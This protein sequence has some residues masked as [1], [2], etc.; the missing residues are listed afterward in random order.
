[1]SKSARALKPEEYIEPYRAE[2][3]IFA[4]SQMGLLLRQKVDPEDIVQDTFISAITNWDKFRG[5]P[6]IPDM[7]AAWLKSILVNEVRENYRRYTTLGRDM[8]REMSLVSGPGSSSAGIDALAQ[9]DQP[10]YDSVLLRER[11]E[12]LRTALR[13]LPLDEQQAIKSRYI[14]QLKIKEIA[15]RLQ[16]SEK[17]VSDR[18]FRALTKLLKIMRA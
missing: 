7:L 3:E 2:L 17:M 9:S 15:E 14:N 10:P 4:V 12:K 13:T 5:N 1:M 18:V 6:D 11:L 16:M 8:K